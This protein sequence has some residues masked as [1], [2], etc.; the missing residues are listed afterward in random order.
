MD[1]QHTYAFVILFLLLGFELPKTY[2]I[3][4]HTNPYH[5]MPQFGGPETKTVSWWLYAHYIT[6]V[7]MAILLCLAILGHK[8]PLNFAAMLQNVCVITILM[9]AS[10]LGGLPTTSAIVV[11][12]ILCSGL[13]Y[14]SRKWTDPK[15]L[16]WY[17]V[18][19]C[20][21]VYFDIPVFLAYL[22]VTFKSFEEQGIN[23][24]LI[25][26]LVWI[27]LSAIVTYNL[28]VQH[29]KRKLLAKVQKTM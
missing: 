26:N 11:N 1:K 23:K 7:S 3:I 13:T 18:L 24:V 22:Y 25:F 17:T 15:F 8:I 16:F 5:L 6:I 10:N 2:F 27:P 12:I 4:N 28:A 29:T 20:L 9:N 19:F 14:L 21:P